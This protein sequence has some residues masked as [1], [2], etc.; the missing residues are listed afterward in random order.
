VELPQSRRKKIFPKD[1]GKGGKS[2]KMAQNGANFWRH[3]RG[4]VPQSA[5]KAQFSDC[6][7]RNAC[8]LNGHNVT[9]LGRAERRRNPS[10]ETLVIGFPRSSG[11]CAAS[12]PPFDFQHSMLDVRLHFRI[13]LVLVVV[14]L[15]L[16]LEKP[17]TPAL[18]AFS[19][20]S[21]RSPTSDRA[22]RPSSLC[23]SHNMSPVS[24]IQGP[25]LKPTVG[26]TRFSFSMNFCEKTAISP[27]VY[28]HPETFRK[29]TIFQ[30]LKKLFL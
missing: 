20:V 13:V 4:R 26:L 19:T 2:R 28:G 14:V 16:F 3:L 25:I 6:S 22:K 24:Q 9:A 10:S 29:T 23:F 27:N 12:R 5:K 17:E 15:G 7:A 21:P 18:L 30:R 8:G 11:I 1:A